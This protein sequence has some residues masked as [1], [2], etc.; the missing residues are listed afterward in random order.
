MQL[1]RPW[2]IKFANGRKKAFKQSTSI[3]ESWLLRA[4][5]MNLYSF[6]FIIMNTKNKR[7]QQIHHAMNERDY[8]EMRESMRKNGEK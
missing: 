5:G 3:R 7:Q 2:V 4:K 1:G 8:Y 6:S